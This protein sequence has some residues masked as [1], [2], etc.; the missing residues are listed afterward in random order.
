MNLKKNIGLVIGGAITLV[1]VVLVLLLLFR[2]SSEY[3]KVSQTLKARLATLENLKKRD[4]FPSKENVMLAADN[5]GQLESKFSELQSILARGQ[6]QP[7]VIQA[8]SFPP[9]LEGIVKDL[10]KQAVIAK[11][12]LPEGFAFGFDR[13]LRG[14]LPNQSDVERL[15]IQVKMVQNVA[16]MLFDARISAL[17]KVNRELFDEK[18]EAPAEA[19]ESRVSRR[20]RMTPTST[21]KST[22]QMSRVQ[23]DEALYT[24][25]PFSILFTAKEAALWEILNLMDSSSMFTVVVNIDA[26]SEIPE[27]TKEEGI[28]GIQDQLSNKNKPAE[29]GMRRRPLDHEERVVSGREE[30]TVKLD[31]DVYR[32]KTDAEKEA[33]K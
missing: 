23:K 16:R 7:E 9:R 20:R 14:E 22:D 4:P 31:F 27:V 5:R 33:S 17:E 29:R 3:R 2:F 8:A 19:A 6:I 32:F 26:T 12:E 25:E 13:Y 21:A 24:S 11:V 15:L 30:L 28:K 18:E 10:R 1:L